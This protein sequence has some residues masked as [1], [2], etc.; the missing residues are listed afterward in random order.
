MAIDAQK[1][2]ILL[3]Q[4]AERLIE[5][6][7]R[8]QRKDEDAM[9]QCNRICCETGAYSVDELA[10]EALKLKQD[11]EA[12]MRRPVHAGVR[13]DLAIPAHFFPAGAKYE[14]PKA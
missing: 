14:P 5:M 12:Q 2:A 3:A 9:R 7:A 1:L 11:V 10:L 6:H 4:G 13:L 8:A